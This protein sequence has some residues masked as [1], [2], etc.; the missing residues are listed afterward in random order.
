MPASIQ[1]PVRLALL[2]ALLAGLSVQASAADPFL[3]ATSSL[4][5]LNFQLIDL[6]LNDGVAPSLSVLRDGY[7]YTY[8]GDPELANYDPEGTTDTVPLMGSTTGSPFTAFSLNRANGTLTISPNSL[9]VKSFTGQN[10]LSTQTRN[11]TN[12]YGDETKRITVTDAETTVGGGGYHSFE[13]ANDQTTF[14]KEGVT[15]VF[16]TRLSA[17]TALI[18]TGQAT[19]SVHADRT[20][21]YAQASAMGADDMSI[22]A[23]AFAFGG[24]GFVLSG[25][26]GNNGASGSFVSNMGMTFEADMTPGVTMFYDGSAGETIVTSDLVL[27]RTITQAFS[28]VGFNNGNVASDMSLD[29]LLRSTTS[30]TF[31]SVK[32]TVVETL[33]PDWVPETPIPTIPEPSTY[34]LMG[35]GLVGLAWASR[36]QRPTKQV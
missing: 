10:D 15:P 29:L 1:K 30:Q 17:N 19:V 8:T 5:N 6:D 25:I 13:W 11:T 28:L 32:S 16:S 7:L 4:S 22:R 35:L 33:N 14:N 18:I 9:M 24:V 27:D 2:T 3:S 20:L 31:K 12:V 36:R 26:S 34:A 23:D 21:L